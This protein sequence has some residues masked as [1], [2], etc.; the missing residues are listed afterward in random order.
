MISDFLPVDQPYL[1]GIDTNS[2][3]RRYD[4]VREIV[5]TSPLQLERSNA[6]KALQR[7]VKELQRRNV[8]M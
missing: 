7:I 2:L 6:D 3:L 4:R 5:A 8:A 1:R